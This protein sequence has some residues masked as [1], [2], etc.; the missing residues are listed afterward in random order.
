MCDYC[1]LGQTTC[2]VSE[3][4]DLCEAFCAHTAP[5]MG[6]LLPSDF[7]L[8]KRGGRNLLLPLSCHPESSEAPGK[9]KNAFPR[10]YCVTAGK[11]SWVHAQLVRKSKHRLWPFIDEPRFNRTALLLKQFLYQA[12]LHR[13][14]T[15]D[16]KREHISS[17]SL[18]QLQSFLTAN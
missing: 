8:R 7:Q 17:S 6:K 5:K 4:L 2:Y 15:G 13:I 12:Y 14:K 1:L 3:E 11:V 10:R 9:F 16:L 18:C